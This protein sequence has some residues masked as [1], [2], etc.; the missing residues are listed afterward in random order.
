MLIGE[1][2]K[3]LRKNKHLTQEE[4]GKLINTDGNTVSRWER[5][6]LGVG[7]SYIA[8]LA[9]ALGTTADYLLKG[10]DEPPQPSEESQLK[11][12]IQ[13][14]NDRLAASMPPK[15]SDDN[16]GQIE[17]RDVNPFLMYENELGLG[18]WGSVVDKARR[19]AN[20]GN[21]QEK[22]SAL[23]M[24]KMAMEALNGEGQ[25]SSALS[26]T[27]NVNGTNNKVTD[28]MNTGKA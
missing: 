19:L 14:L 3:N 2:I 13:D 11:E 10:D 26:Q 17:S 28:F 15:N 4:L 7:S 16:K 9:E 5:D 25:N 6:R 21:E 24:L 23:M 20:I 12:L 8:K 18:Y 27:V 1:K 22:A